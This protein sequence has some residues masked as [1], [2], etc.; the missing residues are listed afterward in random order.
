MFRRLQTFLKLVGLEGKPIYTFGV[1]AGAAFASK[2][3][4]QLSLG[5]CASWPPAVPAALL[6]GRRTRRTCCACAQRSAAQSAAHPAE[7]YMRWCAPLWL[8]PAGPPSASLALSPV[9]HLAASQAQ[10]RGVA[11]PRNL[12][13]V[14]AH[15]EMSVPHVAQRLGDFEHDAAARVVLQPWPAASA[16]ALRQ[17]FG[18]R[19]LCGA[20]PQR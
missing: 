5:G 14:A 10:H 19:Q 8:Q 20:P 6:C 15:A 2:L 18:Q 4:K 16:A 11:G 9:G 17:G 12:C 13:W 7:S 3:P 1:S